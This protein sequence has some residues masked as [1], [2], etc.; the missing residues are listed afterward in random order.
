MIS[1]RALLGTGA[2]VVTVS[3]AALIARATHRLDDVARAVGVRPRPKPA[4]SD[5][6]LL[7]EVAH[8]QNVVLASIEALGARHPARAA[9][10]KPVAICVQ[11]QVE[12]VGGTSAVPTSAAVDADPAAATRA[13]AQSLSAASAARAGDSVKAVSPD[14]AR[15]LASMSAGL[16]QAARTVGGTA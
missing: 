16:A 5:D 8:A 10:L 15:V 6:L 13:L 7:A 4:R 2:G 14:L 9:R 3:G 12:A 1:R 11:E